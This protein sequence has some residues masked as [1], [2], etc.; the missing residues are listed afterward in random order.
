MCNAILAYDIGIGIDLRRAESMSRALADFDSVVARKPPPRYLNFKEEPLRLQFKGDPVSVG[1]H[2]TKPAFEVLVFAFGAVS[3]TYSLPVRGPLAEWVALSAALYDS[4]A[5][6]MHSR[7]FVERMVAKILPAIDRPAI[8]DS[9]EDYTIFHL[10]Q[11]EASDPPV[12]RKE[13]ALEG[14]ATVDFVA[15]SRPNL[16]QI[17]RA[18]TQALSPDEV[19]EALGS[20]IAYGESDAAIVGWN[21]ALL[22]RH[23]DAGDVQSV[24]EYANIE[25]LKLRRLDDQLDRVLARAYVALGRSEG[26]KGWR[27]S[28]PLIPDREVRAVSR[29]QME[30]T[31]LYDGVANALKLAGDPYLARVYRMAGQRMHLSEWDQSISRKLQTADGMYAKLSEGAATRRLE[32]LEWI[33]IVLIALSLLAVFA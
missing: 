11:L 19:A 33:I 18:E 29:L 3:V 7:A 5:L 28:Y 30:S 14:L 1:S 17:L 20:R 15:S 26:G 9:V 22:I 2:S 32:L 8:A 10:T 12:D 27:R 6:H 23:P 31:F 4:P 16:A 21:G 25:L 13:D 24:L